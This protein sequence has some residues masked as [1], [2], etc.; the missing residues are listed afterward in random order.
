[1]AD[2]QIP[3]YAWVNTVGGS[4]PEYAGCIRL[5]ASG[6]VYTIG[7]YSGT[8]DFDPGP[9]LA[10]LDGAGG[11][12]GFITKT[13]PDGKLIWAKMIPARSPMTTFDLD[14]SGNI[15]IPG[16]FSAATLDVG[17]GTAVHTLTR[18]GTTDAYITKLDASGELVWVKQF[19][20]TG[21]TKI[22]ALDIDP[23][24]NICFVGD[25]T[26]ST[27]MDPGPGIADYTGGTGSYTRIFIGRLNASGN[28]SWA[29]SL[30]ASASSFSSAVAIRTDASGNILTTG[31]IHDTVDFDPGPGLEQ[32]S[33]KG[34]ADP[35]M[36][37]LDASGNF[38]FAK[39][40]GGLEPDWAY[41]LAV[42]NEGNV[43]GS[44]TFDGT[45]DF[46][47]GGGGHLVSSVGMRG[48]PDIY[49]V[50]FSS[51]GVLQW[52]NTYGTPGPDKSWA[53]ATDT[54]NNVYL[55]GTFAGTIDFNP[56]GSTP[57]PVIAPHTNAFILKVDKNG[58]FEWVQQFRSESE[59][60][61]TMSSI[62]SL[63]VD[64]GGRIY[65]CGQFRRSI[66]FDPSG[67]TDEIRTCTA[68]ADIFLH[69]L[70][71]RATSIAGAET[72]F[73]SVAPN[74]AAGWISLNFGLE[75]GGIQV[76]VSD[77]AGR[78]VKEQ[79]IPAGAP[80]RLDISNLVPGVY[81]LRVQSG[82]DQF[83]ARIIRE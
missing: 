73:F 46:D 77:L 83:N 52:V 9:G 24:G 41:A 71:A 25:H 36:A 57:A 60:M 27:D 43:Y 50:K 58:D 30:E 75:P 23:S 15:Y 48:S 44:G 28:F 53:L 70:A 45:A 21:D 10:V 33:S 16:F 31:Y 6:N 39:I 49:L 3:G 76:S 82:D 61:H 69:Q 51:S 37:K 67:L 14:A 29:R 38:V 7:T 32:R 65:S 34:M 42:D 64:A 72:A 35:F 63:A 47:P 26:G 59:D 81:M 13:A 1:M 80:R 22:N 79:N 55:S 62:S 4:G 54:E 56:S 74:P 20:G 17:P 11:K 18:K 19:G 8:V 40:M 5:D 68:D 78:R 66:D 12:T 2:A